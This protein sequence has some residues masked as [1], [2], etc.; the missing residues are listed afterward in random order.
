[1]YSGKSHLLTGAAWDR[2]LDWINNTNNKTLS[3]INGD[4]KSWGNYSDS[5]F[6]GHGSLA[7]TAAF[8][9][10][11][12]ANNIYDLAGNVEEWTSENYTADSS[13]PCV[14]R[15]GS[16][17]STGSGFP[18]SDRRSTGEPGCIDSNRF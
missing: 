8:E 14:Y 6:E 10:N 5:P 7:K 4:S 13:R 15:G 17:L 3:Q 1:M 11:T 16:Y 2:T 9:N 18:A 12:K